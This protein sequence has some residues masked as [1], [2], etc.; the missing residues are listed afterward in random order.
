[1]AADNSSSHDSGGKRA[2][3]GC[4]LRVFTPYHEGVWGR[5]RFQKEKVGAYATPRSEP[6]IPVCK[7]LGEAREANGDSADSSVEG[8]DEDLAAWLEKAPSPL[9]NPE[10]LAARKGDQNDGKKWCE[11]KKG[12]PLVGV[13][14]RQ[15]NAEAYMHNHL[16]TNLLIDYL[17]G[18]RYFAKHLVDWDL[19]NNTG[20]W[21][22]S[23]TVFDPVTRAEKYDPKGN[24]IRRLKASVSILDGTSTEMQRFLQCIEYAYAKFEQLSDDEVKKRVPPDLDTNETG[25]RNLWIDVFGIFNFVT[26]YQK[27]GNYEYLRLPGQLVR[28][29]HHVLGRTKDGTSHLPGATDKEPYKGDLG[30]GHDGRKDCYTGTLQT[31]EFRGLNVLPIKLAKAVQPIFVDKDH[32]DTY[33]HLSLD[34]TF[35][36]TTYSACGY[37]R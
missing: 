8:V 2:R 20:G 11:C 21:E 28:R 15:I 29:L 19:R 17:W 32:I 4:P 12:V 18:E 37:S 24:Y 30:L 31:D 23:Y 26:L 5:R 1:M 36:E 13:G 6:A 3:G 14:E 25:P 22:P 16:R 34:E 10:F 9:P 33:F 27:T 35:M 7:A